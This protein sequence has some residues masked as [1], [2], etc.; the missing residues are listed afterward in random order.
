MSTSQNKFNQFALAKAKFLEDARDAPVREGYVHGLISM[1]PALV[2]NNIF[3]IFTYSK[4]TLG[5]FT[6]A[7]C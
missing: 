6:T 3:Q 1:D 7:W 4:S 2:S 5:V